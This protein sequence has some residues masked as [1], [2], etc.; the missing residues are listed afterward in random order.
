[1]APRESDN[2][3][4]FY[5]DSDYMDVGEPD[6]DSP[7]ED[8]GDYQL[9]DDDELANLNQS[10]DTLGPRRMQPLEEKPS[11][12]VA[13]YLFP[14]EKFRG[15]WR[16]HWTYLVRPVR[17]RRRSGRSCSAGSGAG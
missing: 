4:D 13:R 12:F 1:M 11:V 17:H 3:D 10:G 8:L 5:D 9:I 2:S 6:D 14:T 15:E 16:K 7:T